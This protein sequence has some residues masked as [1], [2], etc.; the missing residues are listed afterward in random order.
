MAG[1]EPKGNLVVPVLFGP[2]GELFRMEANADAHLRVVRDHFAT[3]FTF[4]RQLF[5][6]SAVTPPHALTTRGQYTLAA[7]EF[8]VVG[9]L[10]FI[11]LPTAADDSL[12]IRLYLDGIIVADLYC[13]DSTPREACQIIISPQIKLVG[14]DVITLKTQILG[15]NS[16]MLNALVVLEIFT[17]PT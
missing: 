13:D 16:Y 11:G 12:L 7:D 17:S 4:N 8:G 15:S 14:D 2:N 1:T 3:P 9:W 5:S 6:H 10:S